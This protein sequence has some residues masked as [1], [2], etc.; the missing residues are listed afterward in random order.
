M[1]LYSKADIILSML[2][3]FLEVPTVLDSPRPIAEKRDKIFILPRCA[4]F[5]LHSFLSDLT[6]YRRTISH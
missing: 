4:S 1:M 5:T 3:Y 2:A 6:L